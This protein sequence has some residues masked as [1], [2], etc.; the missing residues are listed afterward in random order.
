MALSYRALHWGD[1]GRRPDTIER[2]ALPQAGSSVVLLGEL[3]EVVYRTSKGGE[4]SADWCHAFGRPAP[5]LCVD[6][7]SGLLLIAGGGYRVGRAG[8]VG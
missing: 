6:P 2:V 1:A 7:S 4:P 3:V 8:I 5:L